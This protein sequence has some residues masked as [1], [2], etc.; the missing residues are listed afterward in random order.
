[1][2]AG[3]NWKRPWE[4]ITRESSDVA[5]SALAASRHACV[6]TPQP[7]APNTQLAALAWS[8]TQAPSYGAGGNSQPGPSSTYAVSLLNREVDHLEEKTGYTG[9]LPLPYKRQRVGDGE[10]Y[11]A[12]PPSVPSQAAAATH[13]QGT[14]TTSRACYKR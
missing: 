10:V 9:P 4:E 14:A 5:A 3:S 2:A 12:L 13:L 7:T 1:M 6:S 8:R 11:N